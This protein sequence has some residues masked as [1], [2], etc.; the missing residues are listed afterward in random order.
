MITP[1]QQ[2]ATSRRAELG[3]VVGVSVVTVGAYA[4][5]SLGQD[6][7]LPPNLLVFLAMVL[8]LNVAAH[9]AVRKFA[10]LASPV[11][12]PCALLLNGLGYVVIARLDS[13]LA[14]LQATW[15]AVGVAGFTAIL[16]IVRRARDLERYRYTLGFVGIAL[17]VTPMIPGIGVT[18]NGA[19]LWVRVGGVSFQPG[20]VAKV[21]LALFIA[22]YLVEKRELL[23]RATRQVGP[24]HVPDIR[25]F[26]PLILMCAVSLATLLIQRDLGSSVLLISM[27]IVSL[28]VATGRAIYVVGGAIVGVAGVAL[29]STRLLYVRN[30]LE[31][32]IDPWSDA[33]A[34]GY[35][36]VQAQF[37]MGSGGLFGEGLGRGTPWRVPYAYNDFIFAAIGE[38]LGLLGTTAVI[39]TFCLLASTALSVALR[40]RDPFEQLLATALTTVVSFQAFIIMA[41]VVRVMPLTGI[42]LPFV[43]YGGSSLLT[44]YVIIALLL[45]IS[46]DSTARNYRLRQAGEREVIARLDQ[47]AVS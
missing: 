27:F 46:H 3:L 38:E 20:E 15:S 12:L 19:R 4:T 26:G 10:P 18:I 22:S 34:G 7:A 9:L 6:R 40:A 42:A 45:R 17:L 2:A 24:I 8:T 33:S 23:G 16:W 39:V 13:D 32:W 41:G 25:H 30:R 28:W 47:E 21:C 5:A 37:S 1:E 35:Q 29:A 11:L 31:T 43:A 44:N 14:G 36:L